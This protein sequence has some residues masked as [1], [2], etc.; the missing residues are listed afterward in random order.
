MVG[1]AAKAKYNKI[2]R[3]RRRVLCSIVNTIS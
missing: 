2:F 1:D 3:K